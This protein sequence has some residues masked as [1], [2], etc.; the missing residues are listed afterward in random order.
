MTMQLMIAALFSI[1][2]IFALGVITASLRSVLPRLGE[3]RHAAEHGSPQHVISWRVT[4]IDVTRA[5]AQVSVLPVRA[6]A[7]PAR[8]PAWRA[9]A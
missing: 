9:A 3:L 6:K 8:S 1:A 7:L 4:T 2:G 5:P